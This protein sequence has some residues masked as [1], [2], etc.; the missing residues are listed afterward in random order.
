MCPANDNRNPAVAQARATFTDCARP[1]CVSLKIAISEG[2]QPCLFPD[3][4]NQI[5]LRPRF[6]QGIGV[7]HAFAHRKASWV[8]ES[9]EQTACEA[10]QKLRDIALFEIC[11]LKTG[12]QPQRLSAW[13][14]LRIG[15][16]FPCERK[17]KLVTVLGCQEIPVRSKALFNPGPPLNE[18]FKD[19][20]LPFDCNE[21][22]RCLLFGEFLKEPLPRPRIVV[23]AAIYPYR[24]IHRRF[25]VTMY[26]GQR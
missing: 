19:E 1:T 5:F 18:F 26:P 25:S 15:V 9:L 10:F 12:F 2:F 16:P 14:A 17:G 23:N 24:G 4:I 22:R 13:K 7:G 11:L 21:V 3:A 8:A 20:L 6:W